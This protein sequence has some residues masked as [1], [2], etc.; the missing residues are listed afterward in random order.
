MTSLFLLV[1]RVV[2]SPEYLW[3][4]IPGLVL[5]LFLIFIISPRSLGA[6]DVKL[7]ALLGLG[8]GLE[9]MVVELF[10]MCIIVFLYL[11]GRRLLS[12][13]AQRSVPLAPFLTMGLLVV[14][15][16]L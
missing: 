4:V 12:L 15:V 10:L 7:V 3:G 6:G 1:F 8:I 14:V 16:A 11:G 9:P 5:F 13:E 2:Y